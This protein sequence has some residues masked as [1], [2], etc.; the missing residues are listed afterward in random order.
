MSEAENLEL[1]N[2]IRD[3]TEKSLHWVKLSYDK[4]IS[5]GVKENY[6]DQE[7]EAFE[8]YLARFAR[9]SDIFLM[10]FLRL[11]MIRELKDPGSIIDII[12]SAEKMA[13]TESAETLTQI[14][15]LRNQIAHEYI[16]DYLVALFAKAL[17]LTPALMQTVQAAL[18]YKPQR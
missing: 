15:L 7:F 10:K 5:I 4:C 12:A 18:D 17:T 3:A 16:R 14:R 9:C 11:I 1:Y 13:I 2:D 8:A 6:S